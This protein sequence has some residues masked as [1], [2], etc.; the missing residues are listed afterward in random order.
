MDTLIEILKFTGII[1]I[2][3]LSLTIIF[4][5]FL[6]IKSFIKSLVVINEIESIV[7]DFVNNDATDKYIWFEYLG[8]TGIGKLYNHSNDNETKNIYVTCIFSKTNSVQHLKL[9]KLDKYLPLK[10][11]T[12][13]NDSEIVVNYNKLKLNKIKK[14]D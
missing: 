7:A 11:S 8:D 1:M 13:N 14:N 4:C 2:L 5:I 12:Y 6:F 3:I 9:D 10:V